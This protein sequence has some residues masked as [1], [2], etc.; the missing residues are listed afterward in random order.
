MEKRFAV[1]IFVLVLVL[2]LGMK[3]DSV[4]FISMQEI[5]PA[6][7]LAHCKEETGCKNAWTFCGC[8]N[9]HID[10]GWLGLL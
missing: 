5:V 8:S 4:S 7:N 2:L 9:R 3:L 1:A 10:R 6:S